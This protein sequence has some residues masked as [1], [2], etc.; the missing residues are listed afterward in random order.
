MSPQGAANPRNPRNPRNPSGP[1][2]GEHR[3]EDVDADPLIKQLPSAFMLVRSMA[4]VFSH[5]IGSFKTLSSNISGQFGSLE[6]S[7][8]IHF[9]SQSGFVWTCFAR[10]IWQLVIIFLEKICHKMGDL[11]YSSM[12]SN[13]S[14]QLAHRPLPLIPASL[15]GSTMG[16]CPMPG[17]CNWDVLFLDV[18]THSWPVHFWFFFHDLLRT[19]QNQVSDS[20]SKEWNKSSLAQ[21]MVCIYLYTYVCACVYVYMYVRGGSINGGSPK[22]DAL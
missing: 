3:S 9:S 5:L 4:S 7:H 1:E 20:Q 11:P 2:N 19:C 6:R 21:G 17:K 16:S 13:T 18:A 12:A 14:K 10:K 8:S 15:R 22:M